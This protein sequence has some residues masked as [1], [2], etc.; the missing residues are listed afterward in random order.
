M[1][2]HGVPSLMITFSGGGAPPADHKNK[3]TIATSMSDQSTA[4]AAPQ[5]GTNREPQLAN[6][7]IRLA[8]PDSKLLKSN[9]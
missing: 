2:T 1:G 8:N 5:N 7:A 9:N 6:R 3:I 4:F